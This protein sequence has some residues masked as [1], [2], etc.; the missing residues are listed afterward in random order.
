MKHLSLCGIFVLI[1]VSL[2]AE[3]SP[4]VESI[5]K[6]HRFFAADYSKGIMAIVGADGKI[7]WSKKMNGGCHDAWMLPNGNILWTDS[8]TKTME[9]DPKT[10]KEVWSY[11]S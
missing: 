11:D 5:G 2:P 8:G 9:L 3:D 7:E 6:A 10:D 4:K 1:A